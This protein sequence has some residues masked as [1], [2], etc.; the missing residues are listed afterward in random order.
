MTPVLLYQGP[1]CLEVDAIALAFICALT[2]LLVTCVAP[3][4]WS[5][6]RRLFCCFS[7]WSRVLGWAFALYLIKLLD[8]RNGDV[9]FGY[10]LLFVIAG[11][12]LVV[13]DL[14]EIEPTPRPVGVGISSAV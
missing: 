12:W 1:F 4:H 6:K 14:K 8:E 3:S 11:A 5:F 10:V 13:H 2:S 9:S 7:A